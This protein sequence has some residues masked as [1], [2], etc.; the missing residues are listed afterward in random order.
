MT[1]SRWRAVILDMDGV[2][3]RTAALHARAWK[4]TF[5]AFLEHRARGNDEDHAPF[6]IDTDYRRYVDGRPRFEG[7]RRF[8][9]ARR[10]RLPEGGPGDDED[11]HTVRGLGCRKNAIYLSLLEQEGVETHADT[12]ARL[13]E[14]RRRGFRTALIT[15]SRNGRG[16]IDAAGIGAL[17]D[18][19]IDGADAAKAGLRGKPAPDVFLEAARRL[20]VEPYQ[21]VVLEDAIAGI[22]A[23]RAGGFGLVV[24]VARDGGEMLREHGADVVVRDLLQLREP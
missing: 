10:I 16:V 6:D 14:W 19:I 17:F 20:G 11:A 13:D 9:D 24:G 21:A 12:L 18:V 5:D 4:E 2:V 22:E 8:L 1:G 15:A 3:T 7:I 23:G